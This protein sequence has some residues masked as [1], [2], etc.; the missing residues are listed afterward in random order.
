VAVAIDVKFM[1]D[2]R[3]EKYTRADRDLLIKVDTKLDAVIE[4]VNDLKNNTVARIE[5]LE[6]TKASENEIHE[7][8]ITRSAKW[9]EFTK[10]IEC[11]ERVKIDNT[12]YV[13]LEKRVATVEYWRSWIL[14]IFSIIGVVIALVIYIYMT[15]VKNHQED[16]DEL[17]SLLQQ[18]ILTI[19]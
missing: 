15:D 6:K 4:T 3:E 1:G 14:G 5:A 7:I 2:L 13:D 12:Q 17:K 19:K 10:R 9:D 11:L 8:V 16:L 18:H